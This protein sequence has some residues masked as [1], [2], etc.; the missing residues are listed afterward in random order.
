VE[1]VTVARRQAAYRWLA[2]AAAA[3]VLVA[4]PAVVAAWP[5]PAVRV[6]PA[7]LHRRVRA[8]V[9]QAYEGYAESTA[10]M[11]VP[12][13]PR[14]SDV[15]SLLDGSTQIRAW[16]AGPARWR[17]DVL[18]LAGERDLYQTVDGQYRWDYG[19]NLLTQVVGVQPARLPRGADLLP[20][21]LAR[22]LLAGATGDRLSALPA[23]RVAGRTAAGLRVTP[24]D[25]QT[26][27]DHVDIWALPDTGLP[28]RVEVTGKGNRAPILVTRFLDLRLA[29]P[30]RSVLSPPA[31]G[32][33]VGR[34]ITRTPDIVSALGYPGL[35]LLPATLAGLPRNGPGRAVQGVSGYGA[36][37]GQFVVLPVPR[38]IGLDALRSAEQAGGAPL[39][40]PAGDGFL[41]A[42]PLLTVLVMESTASRRTYVLAG[43]VTGDL[44]RQA[45]AELSTYAPG[46]S[47]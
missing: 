29:T 39:P 1:C 13:L 31:V 14:L 9:N 25:P 21:E 28:L 24:A 20:P 36:G 44:L 17:A 11:G 27:V 18:D 3:A 30:S 32:P 37:L 41:L 7:L 40:L 45:G 38:R 15:A 8:S 34:S 4:T 35:G 23:R 10:T 16:Y 12:D 26:T 43:L 5:V 46:R 42:T 19:E 6:D 2:V 22:R 33:G 47:R